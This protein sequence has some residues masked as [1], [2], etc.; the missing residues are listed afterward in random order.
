MGYG[1]SEVEE[2]LAGFIRSFF[3]NYATAQGKVRWA[4]KTPNYVDCLSEL[5]S[6]FRPDV[7][8]VIILRDGLDVAFSLADPHRHYAAVDQFL[9][10]A[11]GNLPIAA[12]LFWAEKS[13]KIEA[14]RSAHPQA[15]FTLRFEDLTTKPE[16]TLKPLFQFL[17]EPWEPSVID[18]HL[19][20]HHR[21]YEDPDV[22]RRHRI[23]PNSGK[24]QAWPPELQRDVRKACGPML[25]QLGYD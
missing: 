2:A 12:G 5:W 1:K 19:F 16:E 13:E 8:F 14:F 7:R 21:G 18:Y 10:L 23:Q 24:Y 11:N 22:R 25:A 3:D 9:P 15:C 20:P 4:E 17:N 6:L